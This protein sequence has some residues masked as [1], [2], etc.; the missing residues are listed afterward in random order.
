VTPRGATGATA[1]PRG[2]LLRVAEVAELLRVDRGT[3]Y[4]RITA[5]DIPALQ[6][7]GSKTAIRVPEDELEQALYGPPR[8]AA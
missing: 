7:G 6:L 3:V 8:S 1:R 4:R 2:R 5:G